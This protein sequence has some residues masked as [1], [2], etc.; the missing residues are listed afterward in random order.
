VP[1]QSYSYDTLT[2]ELSAI[3]SGTSTATYAYRTGTRQIASVTFAESSTTRLTQT[4][5]YDDL[6]RLTGVTSQTPG[7]VDLAASS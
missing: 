3:S 4:R 2:G 1:S 6:H 7:P 5:A